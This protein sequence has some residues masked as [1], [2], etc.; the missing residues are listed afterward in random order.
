MIDRTQT[1]DDCMIHDPSTDMHSSNSKSALITQ[2]KSASDHT[3]ISS[4]E[5]GHRYTTLPV[6]LITSLQNNHSSLGIDTCRSL[7]LITWLASCVAC[8]K[9]SV[10]HPWRAAV[11]KT[12]IREICDSLALTQFRARS[13]LKILKEL[14]HI[15]IDR[16][17]RG[18]LSIVLLWPLTTSADDPAPAH[19]TN[20]AVLPS[21]H[22]M[23]A[24]KS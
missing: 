3:L 5:I 7:A 15:D 9:D 2:Q 1:D 11:V 14:G 22:Q 6:R 23:Q 20:N 21:T 4:T 13:T 18:S 24:T 10:V 16:S 12:S 8:G 17:Q 19:S